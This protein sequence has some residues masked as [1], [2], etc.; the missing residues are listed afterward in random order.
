MPREG[1][2]SDP[3]K[4]GR[5]TKE[6]KQKEIYLRDLEIVLTQVVQAL[7]N[8]GAQFAPWLAKGDLVAK[9]LLKKDLVEDKAVLET[10]D[11]DKEASSC[12]VCLDFIA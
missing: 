11:F 3:P 10:P 9:M 2:P 1:G 4:E 8:I 12:K 6:R 7:S 5:Q